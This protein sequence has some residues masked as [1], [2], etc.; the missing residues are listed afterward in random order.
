MDGLVKVLEDAGVYIPPNTAFLVQESIL[1]AQESVSGSCSSSRTNNPDN[2]ELFEEI[3][4]VL[5]NPQ[6][7]D[8]EE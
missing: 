6:Q 7:E 8:N 5:D 1:A 2:E 4:A 3:M